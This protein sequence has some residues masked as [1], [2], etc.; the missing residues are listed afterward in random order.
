MRLQGKKAIFI[1]AGQTPG[2]TIGNGRATAI[3][4]AREGAEV[5]CVYRRLDSAQ[6]TVDMIQKEGG[7]AFAHESDI[8]DEAAN[9][10][11][12]KTALETMGR[13][14]ILHNNVGVGFGD[15]AP[16]RLT[17]ET[18]DRIMTVNLKAMWRTTTWKAQNR[19]RFS[20]QEWSGRIEMLW[21]DSP[22]AWN[23]EPPGVGA[24][25]STTGLACTTT[26]PTR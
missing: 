25:P 7:A 8:V 1:G 15:A 13:I 22:W 4:F 2:G 16:H 23:A 11:L 17:E 6:D 10:E 20:S 9:V 24:T 26:S 12:V 14:D 19:L 3:L 18:Y 21:H 5:M